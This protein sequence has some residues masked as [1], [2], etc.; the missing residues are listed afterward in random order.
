MENLLLKLK[1]S[2]KGEYN[3]KPTNT[4]IMLYSDPNVFDKEKA[5]EYD[6]SKI[7]GHKRRNE[8]TKYQE[9]NVSES[10]I[11]VYVHVHVY[12]NV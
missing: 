10:E 11:Y 6:L 3:W 5:K 1:E 2:L 8:N 12:V 9:N 7:I 4:M